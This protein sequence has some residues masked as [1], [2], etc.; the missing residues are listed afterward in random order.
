MS[1]GT[2]LALE[3]CTLS[4]NVAITPRGQ[5]IKAEKVENRLIKFK[6]K[7]HTLRKPSQLT[8]KKKLWNSHKGS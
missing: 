4:T 2:G 6:K 7:I 5:F 3:L 1:L 8:K